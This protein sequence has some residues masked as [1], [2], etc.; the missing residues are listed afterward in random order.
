MQY[1]TAV[2]SRIIASIL[3][4]SVYAIASVI[5]APY[6][7]AGDQL[8]YNLFYES[9]VS[10]DLYDSYDYYQSILGTKEPIYFLLVKMAS[11]I[12]DK[13]YFVAFLNGI[14]TG[15]ISYFFFAFNVSLI[16]RLVFS[17]N[18]YL[19][20]LM[21]AAERLKV[22]FIFAAAAFLY[23]ERIKLILLGLA[24]LAH[25]Q[26]AL[27][28]IGFYLVNAVRDVTRLSG[29]SL[30]RK[31]PF[32]IAVFVVFL[33]I[34]KYQSG[35]IDAKVQA[36]LGHGGALD[37]LKVS[38]FLA[39]GMFLSRRRLEPII[40]GLPILVAAYFFGSERMAILGYVVFLYYGLQLRRGFNPI[41][42]ALGLYFAWKSIFFMANVM[43][44]GSG[45]VA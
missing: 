35:H 1:Y 24:I 26:I 37:V 31:L 36:Y 25:T 38:I 42:L 41:N 27:L 8:Q 22:G 39:L 17:V 45:F 29:G 20:V 40:A 34:I 33:V 5:L 28:V 21:F 9:A 10:M 4:G 43:S 7:Y 30:L 12:V 2:R 14:L 15:L 32:Y 19:L 18:F 44:Y 13:V 11:P 3:I 6:Y 23:S 16:F